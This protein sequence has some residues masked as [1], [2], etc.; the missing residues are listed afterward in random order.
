MQIYSS[1]SKK[2][3]TKLFLMNYRV[4]ERSDS[5]EFEGVRHLNHN[6]FNF[7]ACNSIRFEMQC[8]QKMLTVR[9]YKK[10]FLR[11]ISSI[12]NSSQDPRHCP[13]CFCNSA[14]CFSQAQAAAR[15]SSTLRSAFHPS[16][17]LARAGS[18][19]MAV[20]SPGRRGANL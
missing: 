16:F 8:L 10:N 17:S 3:K 20:T 6:V 11:Q 13:D 5:G 1:I 2:A 18:A 12:R 14:M 15:V 4:S 19:Q 7:F 9:K